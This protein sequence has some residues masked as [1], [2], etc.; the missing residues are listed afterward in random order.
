MVHLY[1]A[2]D[3]GILILVGTVIGAVWV[4]YM[5]RSGMDEAQQSGGEVPE[6]TAAPAATRTLR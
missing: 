5:L 6:I 1:L 3:F 2:G 4:R